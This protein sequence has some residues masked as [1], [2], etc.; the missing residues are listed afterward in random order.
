MHKIEILFHKHSYL[1]NNN[2]KYIIKFRKRSHLN[3]HQIAIKKF[4]QIVKN[5]TELVVFDSF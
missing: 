1:N 2:A 3:K 4:I 5:Q